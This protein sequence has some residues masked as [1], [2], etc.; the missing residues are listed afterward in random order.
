MWISLDIFLFCTTQYMTDTKRTK[1]S[2]E[3]LTKGTILFNSLLH[4]YALQWLTFEML[5]SNSNK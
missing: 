5:T 4:L 2:T 1:T 3:K